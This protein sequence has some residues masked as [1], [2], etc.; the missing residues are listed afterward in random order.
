MWHAGH[1]L[2]YG[3]AII[4]PFFSQKSFPSLLKL[5][6]QA[7]LEPFLGNFGID[8]LLQY[9]APGGIVMEKGPG[10]PRMLSRLVGSTQ[11]LTPQGSPRLGKRNQS[12][13][14]Q[15]TTRTSASPR[16]LGRTL[17]EDSGSPYPEMPPMPSM[18]SRFALR[19]PRRLIRAT[20]VRRCPL[21]CPGP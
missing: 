19:F 1:A 17:S 13:P 5:V 11:S 12:A 7:K 3:S 10:S 18:V 6:E 8:L 21:H 2:T 20:S 4:P 16:P 14:T 15:T 9:P